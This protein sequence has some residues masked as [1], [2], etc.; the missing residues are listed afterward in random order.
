MKDF[1]K[2]VRKRLIDLGMSFTDFCKASKIT[3]VS[4]RDVFKRGDCKYSLLVKV[5][6]VLQCEISDLVE[7]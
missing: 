2:K 5:K 3:A 4:M 7:L 1:E 6:G